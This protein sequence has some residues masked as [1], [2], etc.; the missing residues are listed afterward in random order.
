ML[1]IVGYSIND[2]IIVFDRIRE[3]Q[4]HMKKGDYLSVANRSISQT[5]ARSIY[6]SM[7]TFVMVLVLYIVGVDAIR[8]FALPLMVGILAGT[9][10][11]IFIA[12]PLWYMFNNKRKSA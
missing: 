7:T 10:S 4:I 1:T 2:T 6:T 12:S 8:D 11:S 3:N 9:F 5:L